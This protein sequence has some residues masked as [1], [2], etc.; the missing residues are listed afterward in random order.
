MASSA[1]AVPGAAATDT[2]ALNTQTPRLILRTYKAS[3]HDQIDHL[4]YST[5]FTLVPEGVK[6]K[7]KSPL[8][9]V[10][11]IAFYSYLLN[12]VPVLLAGMN[13]P[14][15]S[16]TALKIFFTF[17]WSVVSFAG[18]FVVTD[19]FEV[20]DKVEQARQNDLSDPEVYYL[21]WT[22]EEVQVDEDEDD[23]SGKKRVTFDKDAKPATEL[24]RKQKPVEEQAPSHF[25][26]LTLDNRPCGMV[27]LAHYKSQLKSNR[28]LQ[29]PAWKLLAAAALA[30]YRLPV[31]ESL[32]D[33]QAKMPTPVFA[34]PHAPNTATLQRLAIK[35]DYQDCNLSTLLIDR[36][37][38]WADEKGI[39]TV[40]AKTNELETKAARILSTR[41]GFKLVKTEKKGWFG[42]HEKTWACNVKEWMAA[43]EEGAKTY[44][45][46]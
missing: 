37:M 11:W 12:I 3:D 33:L 29:P 32:K 31:P 38:S 40:E 19:R 22:K 23:K 44:K 41:H 16:S 24:V 20:V 27:G 36:A 18:V 45:K 17:A 35:T 9:W 14:S 4:F 7:L 26:V 30:R 6:C 13:F 28:P 21:N 2:D 8:F 42:Q 43:H 39:E 25:W 46:K 10:L 34:E 1:S 15:W 5:Y